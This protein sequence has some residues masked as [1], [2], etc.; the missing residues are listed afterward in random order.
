MLTTLIPGSRSERHGD[1]EQLCARE[2]AF[3]RASGREYTT[4]HEDGVVLLLCKQQVNEAQNEDHLVSLSSCG[5]QPL[6]VTNAYLCSG[7]RFL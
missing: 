2:S 1:A 5:S 4:A 6:A 7:L 3:L